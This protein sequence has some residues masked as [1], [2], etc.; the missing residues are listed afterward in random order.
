MISRIACA[1]V[2][3]VVMM[4]GVPAS[5]KSKM[6]GCSEASMAKADG[7]MMKMPEG[8]KYN[9]GYARDDFRQIIYVPKRYDWVF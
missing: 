1:A 4:A 5:A 2:I 7:M 8:E 3:A 6:M 9:D